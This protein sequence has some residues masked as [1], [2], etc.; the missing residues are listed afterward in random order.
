MMGYS[1]TQGGGFS[2]SSVIGVG[3]SII[4]SDGNRAWCPVRIDIVPWK[5]KEK[6]SWLVL[7]LIEA[8][9][10]A[11]DASSHMLTSRNFAVPYGLRQRPY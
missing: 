3:V 8:G 7:N 5:H 11:A 10:R 1:V 4:N 6:K 2:S 9:G